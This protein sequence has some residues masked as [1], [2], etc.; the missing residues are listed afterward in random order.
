MEIVTLLLS[1]FISLLSPTGFVV[2]KVAE[3]TIRSR[4][5]AVEQLR[6]R[7]DNAP[8]YQLLQGKADR[9]RIAARGAFP[10][11]DVRVE[12][13]ELETDPIHL[14]RD[15]LRRGKLK[16]EEPLRAGIRLVVK[17][18]DLNRA[19][20]SPSVAARIRDL[21]TGAI[22]DRDLRQQAQRYRL[23]D[24]QVVL[25]ENRRIRLQLTIQEPNNP[26]KLKIMA[27]SGIEVVAGRQ[28]RL[29]QPVIQV[30]DEAVPPEVMSAIA[31]GVFE[32]L[33]LRQLE[34]DGITLRILQLQISPQEADLA[35]FVQV[36]PGK[37]LALSKP[38]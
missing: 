28:I 7:V 4:L 12:A 29:I 1:S 6:V 11:E 5:V 33:D 36:A 8:S 34:A 19:L 18:A 2:D 30:N 3:K 17:Q 9:L 37:R 32:R 25:L 38:E 35:I 26:A 21:T 24:P 15:R 14:N 10:I 23:I 22:R 27:E 20:R 13:F 31:D 16:L